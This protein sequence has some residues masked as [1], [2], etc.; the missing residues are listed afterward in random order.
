M[1]FFVAAS[2]VMGL[3]S[4]L[5][6]A[7]LASL[8][9]MTI[10]L[11]ALP[12]MK[13]EDLVKP[14]FFLILSFLTWSALTN[15]WTIDGEVSEERLFRV[16]LVLLLSWVC[17]IA[18]N[19]LPLIQSCQN[20]FGL[21][22]TL[23]IVAVA[24]VFII[25]SLPFGETV[26][27]WFGT[28]ASGL[29]DRVGTIFALLV[30]PLVCIST[31]LYR[32]VLEKRRVYAYLIAATLA[33]VTIAVVISPNRTASIGLMIG[34]LTFAL[35]QFVGRARALISAAVL[36]VVLVIP[37]TFVAQPSLLTTIAEDDRLLPELRHR[38]EIWKFTSERARARLLQ[39]WGLGVSRTIP[40]GDSK[41]YFNVEGTDFRLVGEKMPL[42]PHNSFL[43]ILLELGLVGLCLTA[44]LLLYVT[45]EG[46]KA[47]MHSR[48]AVSSFAAFTVSG[49]AL[50]LPSY[51]AWQGWWL[52]TILLLGITMIYF[53]RALR[54]D[55]AA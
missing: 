29:F 1:L 9:A 2:A 16:A 14:S 21:V 20:R 23:V 38:A 44:L 22:S 30:W 25:V 36:G 26:S 40:G 17:C 3:I 55:T 45:K 41:I 37:L 32:Q 31:G 46:V 34:I 43:Q 50:A 11:F 6:M 12:L 49:L 48:V 8:C 42:H 51:G 5:G 52:S 27:V 4:P 53:G 28:N 35:T 54:P 24:S 18:I 39:G 13:R 10:V 15:L 33:F 47:V 19:H 7:P